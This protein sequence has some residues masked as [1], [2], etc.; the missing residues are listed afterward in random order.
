MQYGRGSA[1]PAVIVP[2]VNGATTAHGLC[3]SVS[4][5]L[6]KAHPMPSPLILMASPSSP[7]IPV[8]RMHSSLEFLYTHLLPQFPGVPDAN[9]NSSKRTRQN[10]DWLSREPTSGAEVLLTLG[11]GESST[12]QKYFWPG[13]SH[14]PPCLLWFHKERDHLWGGF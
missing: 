6:F 8:L 4:T 13:P 11:L 7:E 3:T 10:V 2:G 1:S 9:P 12:L 5:L 14:L